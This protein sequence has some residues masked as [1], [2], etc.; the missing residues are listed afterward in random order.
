[1]ISYLAVKMQKYLKR[2]TQKQLIASSSSCLLV[3]RKSIA[4]SWSVTNA[5]E[6]MLVT[7]RL[8]KKAER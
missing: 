4:P 1:M 3:K 2:N 7:S 8:I 6:F 5:I